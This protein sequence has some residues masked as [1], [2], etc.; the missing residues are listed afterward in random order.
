[1]KRVISSDSITILDDN[2]KTML[3]ITEKLTDNVMY[4]KVS[5]E[6]SSSVSYDFED[7]LTA[8][9]S[10]CNKI[11][12]DLNEVTCISSVAIRALLS[13]QQL[14]DKDDEAELRITGMNNAVLEMFKENGFDLLF[15][16]DER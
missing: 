4:F 14:L 1:M 8:A 13:V 7:E 15:N 5:G 16:I 3:R 11:R 10:V 9:A 2:N 6:L 12:L